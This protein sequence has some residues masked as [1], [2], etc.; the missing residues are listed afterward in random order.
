MNIFTNYIKIALRQIAR[1]KLFTLIN[2][3]GLAL[4]MSIGMIIIGMIFSLLKFDQFHENKNRIYRVISNVNEP[5][6]PEDE[7]AIAP[8]PLAERLES[9]TA[10]E[11]TVRIRKSL[12]DYV[13]QDNNEIVLRGY[14]TE[15]SFLK[16][17]S[18]QILRGNPKTALTEPFSIIITQSAARKLFNTEDVLGKTI[19]FKLLGTYKV[20]ALMA[21]VPKHS[22]FIFEAL[23]S[24]STVPILENG[25]PGGDSPVL[26]STTDYWDRIYSTY[27]YLQ[28]KPGASPSQ[29][30]ESLKEIEREVYP[31]KNE[32]N[33]SFRLQPLL[34]IVPG[35]NLSAE[36]GTKMIYLVIFILSGLALLIL[37]AACFNYTNLSIARALQRAKEV[38]LR[39]IAGALKKQIMTQFLMESVFVALIA[40]LAALSIYNIVA[41]HVMQNIPRATELFDL[42]I[43]TPLILAFMAFAIFTG[44]CAGILPSLALS[45]VNIVEALKQIKNL[46]LVGRVGVRNG[47]VIFQFT[48]SLFLFTALIIVYRQYQ[49]SLNKDLGFNK[50]NILIVNLQGSNPAP[51]MNVLQNFSDVQSLSL[52]SNIPGTSST[53]M[54]LIKYNEGRDSLLASYISAELRFIRDLGFEFLSGKNFPDSVSGKHQIIIN[55]KFLALLNAETPIDALDKTVFLGG[56]EKQIIGVVKDFNYSQLENAIEPF[57]FQNKEDEFRYLNVKLSSNNV[58]ET[59]NAIESEWKKLNPDKQYQAAFFDDYIEETYQFYVRLMRVFGFI[60]ITSMAIAILGLLGMA[61]YNTERRTKEIGIRKVLGAEV[62]QIVLLLSKGFV[63]L[64][65]VSAFIALPLAYILFDQVIL[66]VG[67]YRITIGA[68]EMSLGFLVLLTVG[69]GVIFSQ[70]IRVSLS[71]PVKALRTE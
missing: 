44:L 17:F 2:V 26:Y 7:K 37:I 63:T 51:L 16:T 53:N 36:I 21:D 19:S 67:V 64:L 38:G 14:Y 41:P 13:D 20:T 5:N 56:E 15:P 29:V 25:T 23:A 1:H 11:N 12:S 9:L 3:V 24:F 52:S 68:F 10:V 69:C 22:H 32:F 6:R 71:N 47:L 55:E 60:G 34:K 65:L 31:D 33:A 39:K 46:K 4:S 70:T 54:D 42:Q 50:D 40:F 8:I 30:N 59:T 49:F 18:F 28:L 35:P 62:L 58:F 66:N 45:G 57:F 61:S 27:V 48:I 43:N